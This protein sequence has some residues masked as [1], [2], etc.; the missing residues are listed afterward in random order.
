VPVQATLVQQKTVPVQIRAIGNVQP[1]ATVEVRTR[2]GGT[3][4]EVRFREGDEVKRGQILFLIDPRPYEVTLQKAEA[5]LSRDRA[6][7]AK[8]EGD[9]ERSSAL[10]K[11]DFVTREQFD[12]AKTEVASMKATVE[13][14]LAALNEARLELTYCTLRSPIDGFTGDLIAD[15]GNMIQANDATPLVV[16]NQIRPIEVDFSVPQEVLPR[17]RHRRETGVALPVT[18]EIGPAPGRQEVGVLSFMNNTVDTGTGTI[19]LKAEFPNTDSNLWPGQFVDV[20]LTLGQEEGATVVPSQAVQAGQEG[21]YVFVV[22]PDRTVEVR[23]VRVSR[24]LGTETVVD[25]GLAPGETVV[26]DGQLRLVPG[27]AVEI[28]GDAAR[29]DERP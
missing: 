17:I 18:A 16:I 5:F 6:K 14:D 10:V 29:G 15:E 4:D 1:S 2:V 20:V 3:L 24:T 8:A 12:Q 21:D 25:Q 9:L 7:L 19:A 26:T 27:A 11:E 23:P 22:L 13:A 28:K